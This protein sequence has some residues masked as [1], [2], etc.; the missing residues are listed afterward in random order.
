MVDA[1]NF[2]NTHTD[3][4]EQEG[5]ED[6]CIHHTD[7]KERGRPSEIFRNPVSYILKVNMEELKD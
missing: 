6:M 4:E 3:P 2:I 1:P 7:S 5:L